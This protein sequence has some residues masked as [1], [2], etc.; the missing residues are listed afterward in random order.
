MRRVNRV[1]ELADERVRRIVWDVD[2][3]SI[4]PIPGSERNQVRWRF[5]KATLRLASSSIAAS[6]VS[7]P[8][9]TAHASR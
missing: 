7:S 8:S 6:R 9:S 4:H 1:E 5:A 3:E 2:V